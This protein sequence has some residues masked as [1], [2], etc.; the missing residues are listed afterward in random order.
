[1]NPAH[2]GLKETLSSYI[3]PQTCFRSLQERH[4]TD[5]AA[6]AAP[7]LRVGGVKSSPRSD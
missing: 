3:F 4:Q 1:M 5:S 7:R 2:L 6:A